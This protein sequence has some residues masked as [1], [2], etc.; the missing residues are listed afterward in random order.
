MS[1]DWTR[2]IQTRDGRKARVLATDL[3][4]AGNQ[5]IAVAIMGRRNNERLYRF[6]PDGSSCKDPKTGWIINVPTKR[7]GSVSIYRR[8]DGVYIANMNQVI[9]GMAVGVKPEA[10]HIATVPIEWEE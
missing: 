10:E 9:G 2:P 1:I 7:S 6:K 5:S 4:A 8:I 3:Q